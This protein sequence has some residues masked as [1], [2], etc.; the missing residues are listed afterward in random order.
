MLRGWTTGS[1]GREADVLSCFKTCSVWW[2][3]PATLTC[4][5]VLAKVCCSL[6]SSVQDRIPQSKKLKRTQGMLLTQLVLPNPRP[7]SVWVCQQT[8][9]LNPKTLTPIKANCLNKI[10]CS[11]RSYFQVV[12][13]A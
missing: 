9:T 11:Q 7:G 1:L 4:K 8:Y 6:L 3:L 13:P 10:F 2:R 5:D 12:A